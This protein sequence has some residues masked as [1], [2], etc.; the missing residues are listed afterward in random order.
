MAMAEKSR[1]KDSGEILSSIEKRKKGA[2]IPT[3]PPIPAEAGGTGGLISSPLDDLSPNQGEMEDARPLDF[4]KY[5]L[6]GKKRPSQQ[7]KK[8]A[9]PPRKAAPSPQPPAEAPP[10]AAEDEAEAQPKKPTR[11]PAARRGRAAAPP[12][13][14]E[15]EPEAVPEAEPD[16]T[17]PPQPQIQEYTF[18]DFG[19]PAAPPAARRRS[20]KAQ[21]A[22]PEKE[23]REYQFPRV[24]RETPQPESLVPDKEDKRKDFLNRLSSQFEQE[25]SQRFEE[26]KD[27][28]APVEAPSW[29]DEPKAAAKPARTV[30]PTTPTTP[31]TPAMPPLLPEDERA[32]DEEAE[33]FLRA[34][35]E[36]VHREEE[37]RAESFKDTLAE[38]FMRER[39]RYLKELDIQET[40][41]PLDNGLPDW[42]PPVRDP[43]PP[44]NVHPPQHRRLDI[45]IRPEMHM[46]E[47][48]PLPPMTY[49]PSGVAKIQQPSP[50][51]LP[52]TAAAGRPAV[53]PSPQPPAGEE[54]QSVPAGKKSS[55]DLL[56]E[57][58]AQ[59]A[60]RRFEFPAPEPEPQRPLVLTFTPP[61]G[62]V[63]EDLFGAAEKG[64]KKRERRP[65]RLPKVNRI[66]LVSCVAAVLVLALIAWPLT[67]WLRLQDELNNEVS[68]EVTGLPVSE[69]TL[70]VYENREYTTLKHVPDV[71]VRKSGV[72]LSNMKVDNLLVVR[73]IK[74]TGEI[75]LRDVAVDGSIYIQDCA[76]N[77]LRLDNVQTPRIIIS[78]KNA[79]VT[80]QATGATSVDTIEVRTPATIQQQDISGEAGGFRNLLLKQQEG[81]AAPD[82]MLGGLELQSLTTI[83][84]SLVALADGSRVEVMSGTGDL[85]LT[86]NGMVTSLAVAPRGEGEPMVLQVRDTSVTKLNL[87][88]VTD[89]SINAPIDMMLTASPLTVNGQGVLG[90]LVVNSGT[91]AQRIPV[92]LSGTT[93]QSLISD[94]QT[95]IS[96]TGS[97]RINSLTA[98][99]STYALGN[100]VNLLT[101]N[102]E[103]V[104]YENEPDR[105]E[106]KPGVSPPQTV[107]DNPNLDLTSMVGASI[108][109]TTGDNL[110][111][112]C[113]HPRE[114]GGFVK[115]DGSAEA[116]FQVTAPAQLAHVNTHLS[117]H[118]LQTANIDIGD[119]SR[120][121]SGFT[122][123]AGEGT[124]FSGSY[125][126]GGY[127]ISGLRVTSDGE[128]VGLFA[129]NTGV[130][131]NVQVSS[132]DISSTGSGRTY[133]GGIVGLNYQGGRVQ[134]SSNGAKVSGGNSSYAGG[135]A[136]YNY[137]GRVRDCYNYAKVS[138]VTGVGGIVGVNRE[139]SSIVGS[140]NA[141]T[142]EGQ[143]DLGAL[144]GVNTDSTITN[145]YY[146]TDTAPGGV[147]TGSGNVV[148]KSSEELS[149]AQMALDLAYE[150]PD[151][152]WTMPSGGS[153]T[154]PILR[155]TAASSGE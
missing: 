73:E 125:N 90:T 101:V 7:R 111:T 107:A 144:V 21:A 118:F 16:Q 123:I 137:G 45:Q 94:T 147:G 134:A 41:L 4:E 135:I 108:T 36:Q 139:G 114:S 79:R 155:V 69:D 33:L 150:D 1:L 26:K 46:G 63:E 37:V 53:P 15:P 96:A 82:V 30:T 58:A 119:D 87:K 116:P 14:A 44:P 78:N 98:N 66:A 131:Q 153:Y 103:G 71:V 56:L 70:T 106:V 55:A 138:G 124:P 83:G 47:E 127:S 142:I 49:G 84:D 43:Q 112:T 113:N 151:T 148:E 68:N 126:G 99:S 76:V 23:V 128:S 72:T 74:T 10:A 50:E 77:M 152:P 6:P 86:G 149:S 19:A 154:Y 122:M 65:L 115:G 32:A 91:E 81:E 97:A 27:V 3:P 17:E 54:V 22:P 136:G 121:S 29:F 8:A 132:G 100:K 60:L 110:A 80:V 104:I 28:K 109:D 25:F 51:E 62:S 93:V 75:L 102:A 18:E 129:E 85:S 12:A 59:N 141:G 35:G 48:A 5:Q 64:K 38:K 52:Y 2:P 57:L 130:I 40:E 146:L 92:E 61:D 117:S 31:T 20:R 42:E 145:C 24:E 143:S 67:T 9:S 13:K 34:F 89:A 39:E 95:R 11:K 120:Y 105:I 133:V 140:Y 88:G